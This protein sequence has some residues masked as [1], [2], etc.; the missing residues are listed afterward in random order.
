MSKYNS[1][2]GKRIYTCEWRICGCLSNDC[3]CFIVW[4]VLCGCRPPAQCWCPAP[5]RG[6]TPTLTTSPV[7]VF[8]PRFYLGRSPDAAACLSTSSS[9]SVLACWLLL[10]IFGSDTYSYNSFQWRSAGISLDIW[11]LRSWVSRVDQPI[12]DGGPGTKQV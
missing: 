8:Y 6:P 1:V 12:Q 11:G 4:I 2:G 5:A 3:S 7:S 10:F 9:L